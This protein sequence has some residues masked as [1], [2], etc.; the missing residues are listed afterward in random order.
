MKQKVIVTVVV[1]MTISLLGLVSIQLYW[2][3][4]AVFLKEAN[5]ERGVSE[6]MTT[7]I[8]K[9]QKIET[10]QALRMHKKKQEKA[11]RFFSMVDSLNALLSKEAYL[12]R[13]N[14]FFPDSQMFYFGEHIKMEYFDGKENSAIQSFDTSFSYSSHPGIEHGLGYAMNEQNPDFNESAEEVFESM[15]KHS[16]LMGELINDY[17]ASA[18]KME[19]PFQ[20]NSEL[21]DSLIRSEL[22]NK[23]IKTEYEYG[24]YKPAFNQFVIEKTGKHT[25]EMLENGYGFNLYPNDIF[26]PSEYLFVYFP[27][28]KNYLLSQMNAMLGISSFLIIT[29]IF[30]FT[31]TI[32]TV[33]KQKKLSVM[34]NDFINNMTHELKTPIS[35]ISLACQALSDQ[36]VQKSDTLYQTYI[37]VIDD[38]NKRLGLMTEKVLQ[39]ALIE[40]GKIKLN[41]TG[42]DV[43]T[44]IEDIVETFKLQVET[45]SGSINTHFDAGYA[46]IHADKLH[47]T[48]VLYNLLDNAVKYSPE[49]PEIDIYSENNDRG[50]VVSIKDNG[51]GISKAN[52]SKIFDNLYRVPTGNIHNV[53]GFGLG[54]AYVRAI[55]ELHGG[56]ISVDSKLKKGSIFRVFIP[57]G[58]SVN[59][60]IQTQ[61]Q[62]NKEINNH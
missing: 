11:T 50:L 3:R 12:S 57:F 28:Q 6:A 40:N 38:E 23:G 53:K 45:R 41:P 35:T 27:N 56:T 37:K 24:I 14:N 18:E 25:R 8:H 39:T 10:V 26:R 55:V 19:F 44:L 4:N 33:I 43:H 47:I 21:L 1:V 54:L 32:I 17:L 58:F 15:M 36:E 34:K 30:S 49:K 13:N 48:N 5:F 9:I 29:I 7:V 52:L 22:R 59:G 60:C 62:L 2:I 16:K 46:F 51:I 20:I 31:Y 61:N 42:I